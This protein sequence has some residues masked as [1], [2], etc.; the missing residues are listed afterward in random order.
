[1][2]V[3]SSHPCFAA[4]RRMGIA[5][6]LAENMEDWCVDQ[7][8]EYVYMATTKGN[9]ASLTLFT[10]K[11][12]YVH[13]RTPA[14]LVHPVFVHE[15][16][17]SPRV[18]ITKVT[19]DVATAMYR[20]TMGTAE[21]FP[22]DIDAILRNKL[23]EGTWVATFVND[24][25]KELSSLG[26]EGGRGG[27][28]MGGDGGGTGGSSWARGASW[29]ML[30]VWKSNELFKC[31]VKGASW[32]RRTFAA[33]SRWVDF[34]LP[35]CKVASVPN[36]FAPFGVQFMFGLHSEGEKGP[37]LMQSLC[38]H[39]HNL[40]RKHGCQAIMSEV[41]PTDP[42]RNSIPHWEVLSATDDMWC[43]KSL[44]TTTKKSAP[45]QSVFEDFDW[46]EAPEKPVLF[47]DP[48]EV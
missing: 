45:L 38:W 3:F 27:K 17:V 16:P 10:E 37:E 15:R 20:H 13:F 4:C 8:A 22:K 28:V 19:S 39:A 41:S 5:R 36:F 35:W 47:V 1:M 18:Q 33:A 46:C 29:A 30:S 24:S 42:A 34:L 31:E 25:L 9:V 23:C 14:L 11:L 40:A 12:N 32:L 7:D 6:K 48:R 26:C 44:R 43:I 2:M 21:F